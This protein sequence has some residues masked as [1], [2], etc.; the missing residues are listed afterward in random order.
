MRFVN[1]DLGA[2]YQAANIID[3]TGTETAQT[4]VTLNGTTGYHLVGY[5]TP[6]QF[7]V[8][9][10]G[11]DLYNQNNT[12]Q[13]ILGAIQTS[14]GYGYGPDGQPIDFAGPPVTMSNDSVNPDTYVCL[15][16]DVDGYPSM[17]SSVTWSGMPGNSYGVNDLLSP[18]GNWYDAASTTSNTSPP[19]SSFLCSMAWGNTAP[20]AT[21]KTPAGQ[22][23]L[24]GGQPA[25]F[26]IVIGTSGTYTITVGWFLGSNGANEGTPLGDG[27]IAHYAKGN[28]FPD[29]YLLRDD[30]PS[31]LSVTVQ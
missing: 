12:S 24:S 15:A 9:T 17:G 21:Y 28:P 29:V 16:F 8:K 5:I 4:N 1:S 22:P 20:L 7:L 3:S 19:N 6:T 2:A 30:F 26:P 14:T 18:L 11:L 13:I 10:L 27:V 31:R 25:S 23:L